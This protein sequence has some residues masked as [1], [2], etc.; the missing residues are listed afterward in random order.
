[1]P[2]SSPMPS[3]D[4]LRVLPPLTPAQQDRA[5]ALLAERW[6]ALANTVPREI[7]A[8]PLADIFDRWIKAAKPSPGT[9]RRY[10]G[11]LKRLAEFGIHTLAEACDRQRLSRFYESRRAATGGSTANTDMSSLTTLTEYLERSEGVPPEGT[12]ALLRMVRR[13]LKRVDRVRLTF[14][15]IDEVEALARAARTISPVLEL[16]VWVVYWSGL[17][18]CEL[19]RLMREHMD[20]GENPVARVLWLAEELG[21]DGTIKTWREREVPIEAPLKVILLERAPGAGYIF[22]AFRATSHGRSRKIVSYD[23][24]DDNLRKAA[25]LSGIKRVKIDWKL[26]RRSCACRWINSGVDEAKLAEAMGHTPET[27]RRYYKQ[28]RGGYDKSF[29]TTLPKAHRSEQETKKVAKAPQGRTTTRPLTKSDL[30][31][32]HAAERALLKTRAK[33]RAK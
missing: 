31:R 8:T 32:L 23:W 17:R 3:P 20:L 27:F 5:Q 13:R 7:P 19:R 10:K 18:P 25:K 15:E 16:A 22:P 14:L 28:M 6:A 1:M 11:G 26:L 9:V 12:T 29:E 33:G 21:A 2:S 4:P 30:T 24:L